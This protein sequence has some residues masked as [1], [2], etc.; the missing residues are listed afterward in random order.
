MIH[1]FRK[2]QA[3][4][5]ASP[6]VLFPYIGEAACLVNRMGIIT[7]LNDSALELAST[8]M[9]ELMEKNVLKL[10][11]NIPNAEA[12]RMVLSAPASLPLSLKVPVRTGVVQ[13]RLFPSGTGDALLIFQPETG[14]EE[15]TGEKKD[16]IL[17]K[18][19]CNHLATQKQDGILQSLAD[20][21]DHLEAESIWILVPRQSSGGNGLQF[22]SPGF[23]E[24]LP[25]STSNP[26]DTS[27]IISLEGKLTE[28]GLSRLQS[29][30]AFQFPGKL[31]SS[32]PD[33]N[34]RSYLFP[35]TRQEE[36]KALIAVEMPAHIPLKSEF[37]VQLL[38]SLLPVWMDRLQDIQNRNEILREKENLLAELH[39]RAKNNLAI[40][41][42][43]LD[44]FENSGI[45]F[46]AQEL[47]KNIRE[48]IQALSLIYEI[49]SASPNLS[50]LSV[51]QYFEMLLF[52]IES[53]LNSRK[54]P[55]KTLKIEDLFISDM[56]QMITLGL[57]INEIC[58]NAYHHGLLHVPQPHL[59]VE[60]KKEGN[61]LHIHIRD[62]GP[63]IPEN[64]S[65]QPIPDTPGCT[66]IK[67]LTG[68]LKARLEMRSENGILID[69]S[70]PEI[71][72]ES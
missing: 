65:G 59:L 64:L 62:N 22:H 40:L 34:I 3:L 53:N 25:R 55:E 26:N 60:V 56:N 31:R 8:V 27:I 15:I 66:I 9:P 57:L 12:W 4:P 44:L 24:A 14:T 58:L 72:T 68:Q 49:L 20:I 42:G 39:H 70:L 69:L 46:T 33:P 47:G 51:R 16:L 10:F 43:F 32:L 61:G 28:I 67:G 1:L 21:G 23:W 71:R 13:A 30:H 18:K 54:R 5:Q 52:R 38:S 45:P 7:V 63:G 41:A 37:P 2:T 36:L 48:R 29:G 50:R 35:I 19:I 6:E 17:V 11:P